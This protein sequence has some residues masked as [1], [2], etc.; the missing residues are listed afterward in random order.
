MAEQ[1]EKMRKA[2]RQGELVF[3]PLSEQELRTLYPASQ[4][5]SYPRWN[6]LATTVIR[7]G[8][9][10]GHKHEALAETPGAVT[11]LEPERQFMPGLPNMASIASEDRLLLAEEPVR[12]VHPEHKP[13]RLEKGAYVVIVQREYDEVKARRIRD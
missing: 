2:Y 7:E 6:K 12:V 3:L 9:T 1:K 11:L 4:D 10:T 5:A 13:L 8:E